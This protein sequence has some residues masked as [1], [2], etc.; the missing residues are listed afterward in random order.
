[1]DVDDAYRYEAITGSENDV[2]YDEPVTCEERCLY[3]L[4]GIG[5]VALTTAILGAW[6]F[7]GPAVA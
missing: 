2:D 4:L 1:M 3:C 6:L 5:C 7:I